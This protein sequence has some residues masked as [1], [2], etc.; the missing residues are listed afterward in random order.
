MPRF[1]RSSAPAVA[2]APWGGEVDPDVDLHDPDQRSELATHPWTLPAIAAGGMVGSSA[3]YALE[4]AWPQHGVGVPWAT[5]VTNVSGCLLI[6]VTMV[7][8]TERGRRHP[9]WRPFLGVGILGGYTTFSTYAVQVQQAIQK[10]EALLALGYL[11][12]TVAAA[13]VAVAAGTF[14]ARAVFEALGDRRASGA[15]Q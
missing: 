4:Q 11:V 2:H 13:L 14:G 7:A 8:V 9:L 3:R 15:A 10:G 5:L 1:R 12:G 6:G